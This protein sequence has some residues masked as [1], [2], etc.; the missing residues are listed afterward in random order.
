LCD[1]ILVSRHHTLD[2]ILPERLKKKEEV[3][4]K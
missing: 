2:T 4:T 3:T 1:K